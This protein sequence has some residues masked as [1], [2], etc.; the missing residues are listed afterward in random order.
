[1]SLAPDFWCSEHSTGPSIAPEPT[2]A[3]ARNEATGLGEIEHVRTTVI[4][5]DRPQSAPNL[6]RM[7]SRTRLQKEREQT[8]CSRVV[9]LLSRPDAL[10]YKTYHQYTNR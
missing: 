9:I 7:H 8:Q 3:V 2:V 5:V 6:L 4:L 10:S 1:V